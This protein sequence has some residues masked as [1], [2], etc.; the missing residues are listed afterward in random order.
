MRI[1]SLR[2]WTVERPSLLH[3]SR[4][5]IISLCDEKAKHNE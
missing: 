3:R 5:I 4:K 2:V 1:P